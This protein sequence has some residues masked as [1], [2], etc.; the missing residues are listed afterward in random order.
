MDPAVR[1]SKIMLNAAV[2][3]VVPQEYFCSMEIV[4]SI[5]SDPFVTI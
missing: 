3:L 2:L 4:Y 1:R 5:G